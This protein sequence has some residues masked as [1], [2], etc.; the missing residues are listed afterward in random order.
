MWGCPATKYCL[1]GWRLK[2]HSTPFMMLWR[3]DHRRA[4]DLAPTTISFF[5][6]ILLTFLLEFITIPFKILDQPFH[7]FLYNWFMF[8]WL[9]LFYFYFEQAIKLQIYFLVSPFL[10]FNLL[11]MII[12]ILITVF[13][14][15]YK[16]IFFFNFTPFIF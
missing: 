14:I 13:F 4:S 11:N 16:I 8:F 7:F 1:S 15:S 6:L 3:V 12:I 5:F 10:F 9:L 2:V